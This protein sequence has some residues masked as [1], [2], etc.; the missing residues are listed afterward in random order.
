MGSLELAL[1]ESDETGATRLIGRLRDAELI[2]AARGLILEKR[3]AELARLEA[4][5]GAPPLRLVPETEEQ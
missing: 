1:F 2:R 4:E 5:S 3:R